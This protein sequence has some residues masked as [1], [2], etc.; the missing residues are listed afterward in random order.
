M[1]KGRWWAAWFSA[2]RHSSLDCDRGRFKT[3]NL[4]TQHVLPILKYGSVD[5]DTRN[6]T[7]DSEV[8]PLQ[9]ASNSSRLQTPVT[10]GA[11][12]AG[13]FPHMLAYSGGLSSDWRR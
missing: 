2:S 3:G 10:N 9:E 13:E 6:E 12:D 5:I 4:E 8:A 11:C 7:D 1:Y